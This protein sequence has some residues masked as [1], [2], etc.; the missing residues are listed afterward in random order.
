M[1]LGEREEHFT[2][3]GGHIFFFN[4]CSLG[5]RGVGIYIAKKLLDKINGRWCFGLG[6]SVHTSFN[7][8]F[9]SH[10][11]SSTWSGWSCCFTGQFPCMCHL[12][13]GGSGCAGKKGQVQAT[14]SLVVFWIGR[15]HCSLGARSVVGGRVASA[16]ISVVKGLVSVCGGARDTVKLGELGWPPVDHTLVN[17]ALSQ[18]GM[19]RALLGPTV[20]RLWFLSSSGHKFRWLAQQFCSVASERIR[21]WAFFRASGVLDCGSDMTACFAAGF[22][23]PS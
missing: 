18:A 12:Y 10:L 14:E 17:E 16:S 21:V 15:F 20:G 1:K 7:F 5:R 23:G 22:A 6:P 4:R 3:T 11:F 8:V 2:T 13:T 19:V 9:S